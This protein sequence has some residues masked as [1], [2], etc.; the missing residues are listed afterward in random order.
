M[1]HVELFGPPGAGKSTVHTNL[2]ESNQFHGGITKT[3]MDR[4]YYKK[5]SKMEAFLYKLSPELVRNSIMKEFIQYR[6]KNHA[7]VKC[8]NDNPEF[9]GLLSEIH[10]LKLDDPGKVFSL[11]KSTAEEYQ[12]GKTTLRKDETLCLDGGFFQLLLAIQW[13]A[14]QDIITS[15]DYATHVPTP[16]VLVYVNA[17]PDVCLKRQ[18]ERGRVVVSNSWE[19]GDPLD[20][21]TK[22]Q[23][24]CT[25]IINSTPRST[26]VITVNNVRSAKET[27]KHIRKEYNKA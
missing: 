22:L 2:I 10:A 13:R 19:T 9:L 24:M 23:R 5:A 15:T 11:L 18:E 14:Q 1:T 6:F 3:S 12:I 8:I 20:V 17:P 27:A 16:E 21:Q 7:L 25:D 4:L 26:R